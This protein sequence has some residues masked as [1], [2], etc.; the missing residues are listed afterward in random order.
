M[1]LKSLPHSAVRCGPVPH[2]PGHPVRT[3]MKWGHQRPP[4]H[5]VGITPSARTHSLTQEEAMQS[6]RENEPCSATY[7]V[8]EGSSDEGGSV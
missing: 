1:R 4:P 7:T 5:V 2:H 8:R 6:C 3:S